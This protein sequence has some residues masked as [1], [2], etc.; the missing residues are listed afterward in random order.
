MI[1]GAVRAVARA[2]RR[3]GWRGLLLLGVLAG[4]VGGTVLGA[5][6]VGART[7]TAY[8]RLVDAVDLDDARVMVAA[9][10]PSLAAAVP[11]LPGVDHAWVG[12][13]W[14]GRVE[15]APSLRFL[16][17][18][19]GVDRPADL[20][21]PVV[22]AGREPAADAVDEVLIGEP[23][24]EMG[25]Y[26]LGDELTL[27]MLTLTEVAMFDV[28]FGEPD[29]PTVRLRV[30]GIGR[31]PEWGGALSNALT[32]AAFA[33]AY[34]ADAVAIPA[35]V[36][37]TADPGA[38]E[39][40]TDAYLAAAA[41]LDARAPS[42]AAQYLSPFVQLPT[43]EVDPG[44]ATAERALV[45]GLTIFA[46]VLAAGGLL[47]IGQGLLRHHGVQRPTQ[48]V[49]AALGMGQAERVAARVLAA[50]PAAVVGAL[51]AC[52][53]ALAAGLIEPLGS[54]ARYEPDP[55][56]R[57]P[58]VPAVAGTAAV[59]VVF[60]ALVGL[61]AAAA[62]RRDRPRTHADRPVVMTWGRRWPPL[63]VGVRLAL[64]GQNPYRGVSAVATALVATVAIAG[65]VAS[66]VFGA[67][68]S[69]LV[70]E[71]ARYGQGA[72]A[73][74][75]DAREPDIARIAADPRVAALSVTSSSTVRLAGGREVPA[76]AHRP[77]T[78][79]VPPG[80]LVGREPAGP[81]EIAVG[82]RLAAELGIGLGDVLGVQRRVGSTAALTVTGIVVVA[83]ENRSRL[84][85]VVVVA[86]DELPG[87]ALGEP[88]VSAAIL[89][90]PGGADALVAE[91]AREL[92]LAP[93]EMPT[94]VR[95]LADLTRLPELLAVVLGVVAGAALAHILLTAARRHAREVAVLSVLGAT[96]GQVRATLAVVA[97]ATVVPALLLGVPLGIGIA[98]VLWWQV[99]TATG[100]L[101]DIAVPVG[102]LAVTGA[103]VLVGAL[104]FA[105]A[106]ARRAIRRPAPALLGPASLPWARRLPWPQRVTTGPSIRPGGPWRS[107][108]SR[109][110]GARSSS[111]WR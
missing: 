66:V 49:E 73:T 101:G 77:R 17:F 2:D 58:W 62:G 86:P 5:A 33:R 70:D 87:I 97:A 102:L 43:T 20:V 80:P 71:P 30:V 9:D 92:E 38:A 55:G 79:T 46:V 26:A 84:G 25:G 99:A 88:L 39:A 107:H 51:I 59:A 15:D 56:F 93:R 27:K 68:L 95:N 90:V 7:A 31:M 28:G 13:S 10:Q 108:S 14:I 3:R 100:V 23:L 40:F 65:I 54:Q 83:S 98:R 45:V 50:V 110:A 52:G 11:G 29:G 96:P 69:R 109:S 1:G 24:A 85:D 74:L 35:F 94:E 57:P 48:R 32:G 104:L 105:M 61:A 82:P 44:V 19:G 81:G 89:A 63:L 41:E 67:S 111:L 4:I 42:V 103:A 22:V 78:G 91:L 34:A 60:L 64:R 12:A 21:R 6:A 8:P 16:S 53:V 106:P 37:L 36:R 75:V 47:V 76:V 72:D 18:G